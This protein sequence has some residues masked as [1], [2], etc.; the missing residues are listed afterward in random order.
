MCAESGPIFAYATSRVIKNM[1]TGIITAVG[2]ITALERQEDQARFVFA[3]GDLDLSRTRLGDSIAVNG[4]CLT[5]TDLSEQGFSADLSRETLQCTTFSE[6]EVDAAVNLEPA[7]ALGDA[8]GGH[9]VTGHVDG[10]GTVKS[11]HEDGESV[12]LE[13]DALTDIARYI[14][15]KGSICIDGVSLTVNS[16]AGTCFG[17]TIVPHTQTHTIIDNYRPGTQVNLEVDMVA[18]YLERFVQYTGD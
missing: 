8:L 17:L 12:L 3:T 10:I 5:V 9:L 2:R 16:V 13:V 7:L 15:R 11:L 1:F 6:L 18:R 4:A 14:A